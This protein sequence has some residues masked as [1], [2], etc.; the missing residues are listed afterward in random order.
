MPQAEQV[1]DSDLCTESVVNRDGRAR[2]GF[3]RRASENDRRLADPYCLESEVGALRGR[4]DNAVDAPG[5]EP[6]GD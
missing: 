2:I 5:G 3:G 4:D 1:V 6:F